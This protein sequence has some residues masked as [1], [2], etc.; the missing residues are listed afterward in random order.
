M[1]IQIQD[2]QFS[3]RMGVSE[4]TMF[5]D[6]ILC[7]WLIVSEKCHA[8]IFKVAMGYTIRELLTSATDRK[9]HHQVQE[10]LH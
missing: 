8:S 1:S 6:V 3:Y 7:S 10:F 4:S 9:V 5:L 2:F